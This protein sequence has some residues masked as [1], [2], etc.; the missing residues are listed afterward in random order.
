MGDDQNSLPARQLDPAS[1]STGNPNQFGVIALDEEL[2]HSLGLEGKCIDDGGLSVWSFGG[3]GLGCSQKS[4][5]N[6]IKGTTVWTQKPGTVLRLGHDIGLR[7]LGHDLMD[8]LTD[9]HDIKERFQ[10]LFCATPC[11]VFCC[12]MRVDEMFVLG[13]LTFFLFA[14][15]G[16]ELGVKSKLV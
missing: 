12:A 11:V 15:W 10:I 7:N 1:K 2:F 4:E 16:S 8:L 14:E 5:K 9:R 3:T 6:R 13:G